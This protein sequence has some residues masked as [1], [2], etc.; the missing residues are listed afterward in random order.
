LLKAEEKEIYRLWW[1]YLKRNNHYK[2]FLEE[3]RGKDFFLEGLKGGL[4]EPLN[5]TARIFEDVWT[6][7]FEDWWKREMNRAATRVKPD[8]AAKRPHI[9]DALPDV[10]MGISFAYLLFME[11]N[12]DQAPNEDQLKNGFLNHMRSLSRH[13][14]VTLCL[15]L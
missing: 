6:Q 8:P 7:S 9:E 4:H 1:E 11:R 12:Y 2:T 14:K 5:F 13:G 3:N 10:L 15:T